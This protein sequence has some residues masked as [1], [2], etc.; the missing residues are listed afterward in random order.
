MKRQRRA[1]GGAAGVVES[2][3]FIPAVARWV[4]AL[5]CVAA[6]AFMPL[7]FRRLALAATGL[8]RWL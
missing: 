8:L 7:W 4:A 5:I 6:I 3:A 1:V 2:V